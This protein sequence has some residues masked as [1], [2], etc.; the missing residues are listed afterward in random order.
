M[1]LGILAKGPV[2][3]VIPLGTA[4]LFLMFTKKRRLLGRLNWFLGLLLFLLIVSPWFI[5]IYFLV[6]RDK[7]EL[8]YVQQ[9]WVWLTGGGEWYKGYLYIPYLFIGFFPW[10]LALPKVFLSKWRERDDKTVFLWVWFFWV[11]FIFVLTGKKVSRYILPLYPAIS[12][13][14]A[15]TIRLK[16]G[17]IASVTIV[18]ISLIMFIIYYIPI[19]RDN[20]SPKP[21]CEMLKGEI[22]EG[23]ALKAYKSWDNTIR[24]YLGKHVDIMRT[25]GELLGFLNSREKVY[26][27]MWDDVYRNLPEEIKGK[28]FIVKTGYKVL[29]NR[30]VLVSNKR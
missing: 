25:E 13:L 26:C 14:T 19:E 9:N 28:V 29:E 10:S 8:F 12:L 21:F 11:F 1:G 27:F 6:P 4:V 16:R 20:Y 5:A 3:V 24:Y 30:V 7:S 15:S 22:P 2:G 18:F 17:F 23:A